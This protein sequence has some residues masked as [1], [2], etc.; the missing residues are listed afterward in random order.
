MCPALARSPSPSQQILAGKPT[1]NAG[2]L[3]WAERAKLRAR[4]Q[5]LER[6]LLALQRELAEYETTGDLIRRKRDLAALQMLQAEA[7]VEQW[8]NSFAPRRNERQ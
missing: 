4:H 8:A 3:V 5:R 1:Q 7:E 2:P 6:E